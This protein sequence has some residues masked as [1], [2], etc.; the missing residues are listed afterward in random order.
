[1]K[2]EKAFEF[3][4]KVLHLENEKSFCVSVKEVNSTKNL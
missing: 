4:K 3:Q 2:A 1:M